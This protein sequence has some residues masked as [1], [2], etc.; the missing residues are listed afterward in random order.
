LGRND[1]EAGDVRGGRGFADFAPA[2]GSARVR[3]YVGE[4]LK[5]RRCRDCAD[6]DWESFW[7]AYSFGL[8]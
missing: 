1:E 8:K 2:G 6:A 5:I 7:A 3:L 4:G